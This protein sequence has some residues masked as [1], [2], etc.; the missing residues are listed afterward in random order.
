MSRNILAIDI[1][2]TTIA[3]VLLNTG[4]K[5]S[6]V[7]NCLFVPL[8]ADSK[9][10]DALTK[11]IDAV[12]QHFDTGGTNIIAAI[13]SDQAFYRTLQVPFN[14]EKKIRQILPFEIESFMPVDVDQLIIDF[15]KGKQNEHTDLLITAIEQQSLQYYLDIFNSLNKQP[16]LVV[17]GPLPTLLNILYAQEEPADQAVLLDVDA[18]KASVYA[19]SDGNV[20]LVRNLNADIQNEAGIEKLALQVRQTLTAYGD[21]MAREFTPQVVYLGGPAMREETCRRSLSNALAWP[22]EFIDLRKISPKVEIGDTIETYN[23]W[24][25]DNALG[26][27]ILEIEGR[28]CPS[29]HRSSSPLRDFWNS[30]RSYILGPALLLAIAL[31]LGL[32]G[33]VLENVMLQKQVDKINDQ[34]KTVFN[35]AFPGIKPLDDTLI[36]MKSKIKELQAGSSGAVQGGSNVKILDILNE[37]SKLIPKEVDVHF[38]RLVVGADSVTI[39]GKAAAFNVVD[40]VKSRLEQCQWFKQVE[41]ASANMDKSGNAVSFKFSIDI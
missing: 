12:L 11:G 15:Q 21:S 28:S 34:M 4:L 17:P 13:P 41:I 36:H 2:S 30:Y 16:Q 10:A 3:A 14:D 29:F 38:T 19:V 33:I 7:Q 40:D 8:T 20:A 26:L 35:S 18:A 23:P 39:S 32:G 6:V 1:R 27:A 37:I 25:M 31:L 5:T 9:D 22:V 24:L